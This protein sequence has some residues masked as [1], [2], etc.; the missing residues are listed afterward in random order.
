MALYDTASYA[1]SRLITDAYSTS[2]GMSIRLFDVTFRPHIY[3]IYGLVRIADEIVDTYKGE[4]AST[5][6]DELEQDTYRAIS[7]GYSAN[8]LVHAFAITARQ[9]AIDASLIAPFF[10]SM[11][12]DLEPRTYDASTYAQYIVG[13]AEVVGLMCLKVFLE[14]DHA[15][16]A[17]LESGARHL[18]AAYQKVNFLRDI[19][20]D[21]AIGRWYFPNGSFDTFDEH[22]KAAIVDDITNDLILAQ[23]AIHELPDSCRRAVAL[24]EVYYR[25]LLEKIKATPAHT[26]QST[27]IR[28]PTSEKLL[29]LAKT[30]LRN[31]R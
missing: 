28:V 6:L 17:Q 22:Q 15:R 23:A 14:G 16:Y 21:H 2:F 7:L 24:S 1:A 19:A 27:R 4:G 29:L 10:T 13:S 12:M 9:Y 8:P 26:L 11:R 31:G 18:G 5:M 25:R 30:K 3:A 20:A